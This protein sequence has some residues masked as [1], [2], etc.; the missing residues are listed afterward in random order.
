M[1][2]D[3]AV[4]DLA[5]TTVRDNHDVHRVLI[6][7][8]KKHG[9]DAPF[10]EVNR[11]MGI[12]KPVAIE[13]LLRGHY[14]GEKE[15]SAAWIEEIHKDFLHGM[16]NF[17]T[18][19]LSVSEIE[20]VSEVFADLRKRG[21]KVFVD[22]GFDRSIADVLLRR[23]GWLERDLVNGSVT[24]DEVTFGR[25]YPDLIHRAMEL[26]GVADSSRVAKIGDTTSD[27]LEGY[28]ARCGYVI[29]VTS[30]AHSRQIL[31]KYY[32][33]HLIDNIGAVTALLR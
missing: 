14:L 2:V 16:I 20:G 25:P 21:V 23:M 8:L 10:D 6:S 7:A 33:T 22:T 17:Y 9:V 11:V 12:P 5:G 31:E 27:L 15:I 19:D 28:N 24:S 32:H 4:F 26:A 18:S 1:K 29:G 30:G 3:L 13:D